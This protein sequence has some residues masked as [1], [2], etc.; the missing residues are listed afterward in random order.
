MGRSVLGPLGAFWGPKNAL[1]CP[2]ASINAPKR[3]RIPLGALK[4][5]QNASKIAYV[6]NRYCGAARDVGQCG[7]WSQFVGHLTAELHRVR[8]CVRVR[9]I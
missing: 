1:K 9:G 6:T 8:V 7:T 3:P 5:N 2:N 4:I